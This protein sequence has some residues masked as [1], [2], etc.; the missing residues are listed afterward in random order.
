MVKVAEGCMQPDL[1]RFFVRSILLFFLSLVLWYELGDWQVRKAAQFA[2][3]VLPHL[4]PFADY[5]I[6]IQGKCINL[7][8]LIPPHAPDPGTV[9][10]KSYPLLQLSG[11]PLY[12]ALMLAAPSA[13]KHLKSLALGLLIVA[14]TGMIGVVIEASRHLLTGLVMLNV[15]LNKLAGLPAYAPFFAKYLELTSMLLLPLILPVAVW[16]WQRRDFI[17]R[18]IS[19]PERKLV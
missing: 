15:D 1:K 4:H 13:M 17:S 6:Q 9:R 18:L 5:V 11:I 14:V 2:G 7:L 19:Q 3:L 8:M 10:G 12:S 16:A